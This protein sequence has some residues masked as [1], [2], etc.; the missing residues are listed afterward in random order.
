M[1]TFSDLDKQFIREG[2]HIATGNDPG[3]VHP[4]FF[5]GG[6]ADVRMLDVD[7]SAGKYPHFKSLLV[8]LDGKCLEFGE[9]GQ[10]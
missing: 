9:S 7:N 5:I 8:N 2:I 4:E 1:K 3:V 10:N 6:K